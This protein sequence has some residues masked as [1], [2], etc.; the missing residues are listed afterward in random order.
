M[1][2][3]K[4]IKMPIKH[5]ATIRDRDELSV[6]CELTYRWLKFSD[7]YTDAQNRKVA[8]VDVMTTNIDGVDKKLCGLAVSI[9]ELSKIINKI[10]QKE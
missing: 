6:N 3:D 5:P 1:D 7:I 4:V 2:R 9:D 8:F 10:Q